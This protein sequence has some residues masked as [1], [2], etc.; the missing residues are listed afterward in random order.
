M[1]TAN[2]ADTLEIP[3]A[4]VDEKTNFTT[5]FSCSKMFSVMFSIIGLYKH[6]R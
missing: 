1:I 5:K 3:S 2:V 6:R 4:V